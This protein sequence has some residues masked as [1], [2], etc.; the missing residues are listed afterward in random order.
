M[1]DAPG[2]SL[3]VD[4]VSSSSAV[5]ARIFATE[6]ARIKQTETY[7]AITEDAYHLDH[8]RSTATGTGGAPE[9][10][11]NVGPVIVRLASASRSALRLLAP[12]VR[13]E[14]LAR[15]RLPRP[16]PTP[17]PDLRWTFPTDGQLR[18]EPVVAGGAVHAWGWGA[19]GVLYAL[20][21]RTGRLRWPFAPG[22]VYAGA[23]GDVHALRPTP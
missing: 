21:A 7:D 1:D 9:V 14:L 12:L 22:T 3:S 17:R 18:D 16:V 8:I 4:W 6:T 20:D 2:V 10:L 13:N 15:Y 11:V 23:G 19:A 5:A